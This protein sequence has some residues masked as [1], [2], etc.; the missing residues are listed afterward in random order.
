MN[1]LFL[2]QFLNVSIN[3]GLQLQMYKLSQEENDCC[4]TL[5]PHLSLN[6]ISYIITVYTCKQRP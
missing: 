2:Q 4:K 5:P 6:L 3:M 1:V